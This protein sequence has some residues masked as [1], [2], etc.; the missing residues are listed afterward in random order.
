M[1]ILIVW[2]SEAINKYLL[3]LSMGHLFAHAGPNSYIYVYII[4][5]KKRKIKLEEMILLM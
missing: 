3:F 5:E 4:K 1:Y 2:S